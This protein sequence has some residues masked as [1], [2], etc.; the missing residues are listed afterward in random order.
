LPNLQAQQ[1]HCGKIK[2]S[3][4]GNGFSFSLAIL[5]V[6]PPM[7]L[8]SN[9]FALNCKDMDMDFICQVIMGRGQKAEEKKLELLL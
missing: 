1:L 5:V 4:E 2:Q 3:S 8:P 6:V 7:F 9:Q